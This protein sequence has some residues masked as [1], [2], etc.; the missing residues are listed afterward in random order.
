M[1]DERVRRTRRD[2]HGSKLVG[3][4]GRYRR[5][6]AVMAATAAAAMVAIACGDVPALEGSSGSPEAPEAT[7]TIR[8]PLGGAFDPTCGQ[9]LPTETQAEYAKKCDDAIGDTVPTFNCDVGTLVP[10]TH[11]TGTYPSMSCDRPNVLN[12]QC[13]PGSRFQ[14]L[15]SANPNVLMVAHCRRKGGTT[16]YGDVA[17]IQYNKAN[18]A[19]CFY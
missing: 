18:G 2:S 1:L 4:G 6:A 13:D 17:V 16:T 19:T 7:G 10:T 5:V 3:T 12:S 14:V 11:Q 9:G 15:P 8:Q